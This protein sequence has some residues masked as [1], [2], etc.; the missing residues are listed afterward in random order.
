M[1]KR[2][3]IFTLMLSLCFTALFELVFSPLISSIVIAVASFV[4]FFVGFLW[5]LIDIYFDRLG[6]NYNR[7]NLIKD[8][9]FIIVGFIAVSLCSV[10]YLT[11]GKVFANILFVILTVSMIVVKFFKD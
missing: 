11:Y 5:L 7:K 1:S 9:V 10:V 6:Y 8:M 3:S 4:L 2:A